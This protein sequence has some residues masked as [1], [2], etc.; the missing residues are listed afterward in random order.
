[1]AKAY[2][3]APP[4]ILAIRPPMSKIHPVSNIPARL[5]TKECNADVQLLLRAN[6]G[7][8][9]QIGEEGRK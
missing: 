2:L 1:M 3:P 5:R 6:R 7:A 9:L 8:D 4:H